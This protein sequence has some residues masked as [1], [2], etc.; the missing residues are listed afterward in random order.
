[1]L[2]ATTLCVAVADLRGGGYARLDR[3]GAGV[4]EARP[5][6]HRPHLGVNVPGGKATVH[7]AVPRLG[8]LFGGLVSRAPAAGGACESTSN[9]RGDCTDS[10]F[11][12][13]SGAA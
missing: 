5:R 6:V 11:R 13:G 12:A 7:G 2:S 8:E 9:L 10:P 3:E 4:L 1:M